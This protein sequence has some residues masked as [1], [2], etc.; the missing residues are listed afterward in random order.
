MI[1][2]TLSEVGSSMPILRIIE[3][4]QSDRHRV[5]KAIKHII[6]DFGLVSS[7]SIPGREVEKFGALPDYYFPPKKVF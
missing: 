7:V 2:V 6:K 5:T 4:R 3:Q 1:T